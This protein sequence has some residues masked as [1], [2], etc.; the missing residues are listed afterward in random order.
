MTCFCIEILGESS[1]HKFLVQ[2]GWSG[3]EYAFHYNAATN[4]HMRAYRDI[5][6][7]RAERVD[8]HKSANTW[9]LL[10]NLVEEREIEPHIFVDGPPQAVARPARGRKGSQTAGEA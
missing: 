4:S 9:P 6:S 2:S 5:A 8:L 1:F 7:Y 3:K 10:G